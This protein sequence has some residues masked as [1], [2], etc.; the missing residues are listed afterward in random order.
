MFIFYY[1]LRKKFKTRSG[2]SVKL[3]DLLDEGLQKSLQKLKE[4]KRDEAS[5]NLNKLKIC[6]WNWFT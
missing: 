5:Y 1:V 4:K 3:A 6:K 2:E